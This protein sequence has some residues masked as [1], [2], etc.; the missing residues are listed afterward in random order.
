MSKNNSPSPAIADSGLVIF[1][2]V[3]HNGT[4]NKNTLYNYASM[5]AGGEHYTFSHRAFAFRY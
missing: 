2:I 5:F 4:A 1:F 3:T